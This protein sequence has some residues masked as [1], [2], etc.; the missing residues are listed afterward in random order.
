[1]AQPRRMKIEIFLQILFLFYETLCW[2]KTRI[3]YKLSSE[4]NDFVK[5][6]KKIPVKPQLLGSPFST[7]LLV[8]L[9]PLHIRTGEAV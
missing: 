7:E 8:L 2:G 3:N 4:E 5:E 6:K 9:D 1:M